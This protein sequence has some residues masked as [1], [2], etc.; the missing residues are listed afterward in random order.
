MG[1]VDDGKLLGG[2]LVALQNLDIGICANVDTLDLPEVE[3]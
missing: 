2:F 3:G 1:A